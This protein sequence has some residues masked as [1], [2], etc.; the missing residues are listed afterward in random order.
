M[1]FKVT[2][3]GPPRIRR[4]TIIVG[5]VVFTAEDLTNPAV[6]VSVSDLTDVDLTGLADGDILI[7]DAGTSTWIVGQQAMWRPLMA[8][9]PDDDHWHVVVAADGTAVMVEG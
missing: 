8:F 5:G 6:S 1:S 7:W 2:S 9:D 3:L 4:D